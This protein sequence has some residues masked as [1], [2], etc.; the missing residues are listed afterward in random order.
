M[1]AGTENGH[2]W[3]QDTGHF[4]GWHECST[5][6]VHNLC[7]VLVDQTL[8]CI[9]LFEPDHGAH[10]GWDECATRPVHRL[11]GVLVGQVRRA[12]GETVQRLKNRLDY[13]KLFSLNVFKRV[14][15]TYINT[16]T[17]TQT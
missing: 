2:T 10:C 7:G 5:R 11:R 14:A 16:Q 9:C 12:R 4:L 13:I 3:K 15:G 1:G 8:Q 17:H 6:P